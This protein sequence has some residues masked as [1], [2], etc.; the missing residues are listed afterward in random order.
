MCSF[1]SWP[2]NAVSAIETKNA[3]SLKQTIQILNKARDR[4]I[5]NH[6]S[7]HSPLDESVSSDED[8][9]TFLSYFDG[10]IYH[11][12]RE[13][14]NI[15]GSDA[16]KDTPCP[17][18]QNDTYT[19]SQYDPV[20]DISVQTNEDRIA[21]LEQDLNTSL[22]DFDD[23]LLKE[24]ETLDQK[25][26][27]QQ[28]GTDSGEGASQGNLGSDTSGS[29]GEKQQNKQG[30]K[31]Q[32]DQMSRSGNNNVDPSKGGD[33]GSNRGS[34]T[35]STKQSRIPPTAG[36][37]ELTRDDDIVAKQLREAAEQETD[38]E[39]KEKLWEE[40]RKYKEGIE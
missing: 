24:Q 19:P 29:D 36:K 9:L 2:Q 22:S 31:E 34:G 4:I 11:Y 39:V 21:S 6:Q 18:V 30:S 20:P 35:G 14:Y 12:C 7:P 8:F 10:R 26:T 13:L 5:Q 38:P 1:C 40:Y 32:T 25:I 23:M 27:R 15:I 17:L 16:L 37:K 33:V 3:A 28:A